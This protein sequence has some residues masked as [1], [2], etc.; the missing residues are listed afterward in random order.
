L[1]IYSIPRDAGRGRNLN[2]YHQQNFNL[3]PQQQ[4][5]PRPQDATIG[6]ENEAEFQAVWDK[7][8]EEF[9]KFESVFLFVLLVIF[10]LTQIFKTSISA[11]VITFQAVASLYLFVYISKYLIAQRIQDKTRYTYNILETILYLAFLFNVQES[12]LLGGSNQTSNFVTILL[13]LNLFLR[14]LYSYIQQKASPW[15]F[16][17][18]VSKQELLCKVLLLLQV[19]LIIL[20]CDARYRFHGA[21]L[22]LPL[23]FVGLVLLINL[24]SISKKLL[25]PNGKLLFSPLNRQKTLGLGWTYGIPLGLIFCI[26]WGVFELSGMVYD[27]DF[28]DEDNE[29]VFRALLMTIG[30]LFICLIYTRYYRNEVLLIGK[31]L[32][33]LFDTD[34]ANQEKVL[35]YV[36]KLQEDQK[37]AE[38]DKIQPEYLLKASGSYFKLPDKKQ[39]KS[40]QRDL[41]K[42]SAKTPEIALEKQDQPEVVDIEAFEHGKC[43]ICF[44]SDS[45]AVYLPCGH[46]GIC[47]VCAQELLKVKKECHFCRSEI[48]RLIQIEP[49]EITNN[50]VKVKNISKID[51]SRQI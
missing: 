3:L 14:T 46:G 40:L 1:E 20:K 21:L 32:V 41:K 18:H 45:D 34:P 6:M 31:Y 24:I 37:R 26:G 27:W 39:I 22:F 13:L 16:I 25:S 8:L 7:Y 44:D 51:S 5:N 10:I 12:T 19:A 43:V 4:N 35:D 28:E 48:R 29:N 11:V 36:R 38:E 23:L 42:S 17:R 47:Y 15:P 50:Y 2:N 9:C 49:K 33:C 30:T